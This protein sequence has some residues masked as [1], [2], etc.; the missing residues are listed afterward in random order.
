MLVVVSP[1][2]KL[3]MKL[4]VEK[5]KTS[6]PVFS[7]DI[8]RLVK[9][10]NQLSEEGL[11]S[12]MKISPALARLNKERFNNFGSQERK[13]AAFAFAGDTYTGFDAKSLDEDALR[14]A[15]DHMR[16]LSGLYGLLRPLDEIEPYR[17]EMGS[18]LKVENTSDLYTYWGNRLSNELNR[19]AKSM[20]LSLIHI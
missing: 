6:K 12:L 9:A 14:W 2:K 7:N 11:Q 16:I 15:Q 3:D 13:P 4:K 20:K 1:A 5:V 17:L 18:R 8:G 19:Q 10:A